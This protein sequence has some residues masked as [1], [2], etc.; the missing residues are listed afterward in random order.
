VAIDYI[1][2]RYIGDLKLGETPSIAQE[3][4]TRPVY[5]HVAT[6]DP[7]IQQHPHFVLR[8]QLADYF[9]VVGDA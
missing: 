9:S 1:G 3:V 2:E 6:R 7:N 5:F 4:C 8:Y